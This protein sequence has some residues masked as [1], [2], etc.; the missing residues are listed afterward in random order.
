MR[1][2][3]P[4]LSVWYDDLMAL[5]GV[6]GMKQFKGSD[7]CSTFVGLSELTGHAF[8]IWFRSTSHDRSMK[9]RRLGESQP[10]SL[11]L[12]GYMVVGTTVGDDV[13]ITTK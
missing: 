3:H 13:L 9:H 12:L 8:L 7:D 5:P 10:K 6:R 4:Q 1:P 2:A 11:L